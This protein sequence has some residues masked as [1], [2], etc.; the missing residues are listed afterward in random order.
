MVSNSDYDA[1][2]D[3]FC[4]KITVSVPESKSVINLS[5][6]T[7]RVDFSLTNSLGKNLGF[8]IIVKGYHKSQYI[9]DIT[10]V[11]SVLVNVDII[12]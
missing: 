5:N 1:V 7:Y 4:I 9:V 6:P 11:N 12:S 10:T 3:E 2:K 8:E